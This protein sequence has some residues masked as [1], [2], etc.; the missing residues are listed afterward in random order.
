MTENPD[1]LFLVALDA[2][3][4]DAL[5]R[6]RPGFDLSLKLTRAVPFEKAEKDRELHAAQERLLAR[7]RRRAKKAA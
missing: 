4:R 1:N 5:V 2:E 3:E 7:A 6:M